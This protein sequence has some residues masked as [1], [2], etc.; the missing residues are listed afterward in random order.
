MR[1]VQFC[2]SWEVIGM[3]LNN[4]RIFFNIYSL[5]ITNLFLMGLRP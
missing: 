3:D 5:C 4:P 2:L 1:D